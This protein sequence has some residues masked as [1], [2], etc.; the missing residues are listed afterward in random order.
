VVLPG[1]E[2]FVVPVNFVLV[3]ELVVFRTD[4]G[5]HAASCA[6]RSV[7]FEVD[8][9]D[10]ATEAGWSVVV[11]GPLE[12]MTEWVAADRRFRELVEPW[13]PG[14]KDRWLAVQIADISGRWVHGADPRSS[15][16]DERGYP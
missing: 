10:V 6:G 7:A 1:L 11:S 16:V 4:A 15:H 14:P 5:S 3:D 8:A 2:P 13:A 9:V 12:D